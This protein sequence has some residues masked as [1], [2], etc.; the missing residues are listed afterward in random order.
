MEQNKKKK[1]LF[2]LGSISKKNIIIFLFSP[3]T[4]SL[5]NKFSEKKNKK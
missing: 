2:T 4:F 5:N 1:C 3:L